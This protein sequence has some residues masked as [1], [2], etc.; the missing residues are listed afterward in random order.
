MMSTIVIAVLVFLFLAP[1]NL[2]M[3]RDIIG[4]TPELGKK[5]IYVILVWL[6][7]LL[8][9]YI[10]D[11][12][13]K[14]GWFNRP[15]K[16]GGAV[17]GGLFLLDSFFNPGARHMVELVENKEKMVTQAEKKQPQDKDDCVVSDKTDTEEKSRH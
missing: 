13:L 15:S 6:L 12:K 5:I 3:S 8:G 4:W 16:S 10:V 17:T 2:L 7:P 1:F 14:L 9:L 11:K